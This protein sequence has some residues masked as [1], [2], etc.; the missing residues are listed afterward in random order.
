V[1]EFM[2][3]NLSSKQEHV[4]QQEANFACRNI[5]ENLI[6]DLVFLSLAKR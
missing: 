5:A 3:Q 4:M 6:V 2:P 1:Q